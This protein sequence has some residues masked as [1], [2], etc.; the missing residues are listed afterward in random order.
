MS[1]RDWRDEL[2]DADLDL[3]RDDTMANDADYEEG[4]PHE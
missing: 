3:L 1:A 2:S 4:A